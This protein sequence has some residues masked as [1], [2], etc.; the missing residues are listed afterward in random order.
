[1]TTTKTNLGNT[2]ER[3]KQL[4][5]EPVGTI[6][7]TN[8][9]DAIENVAILYSGV[10]GVPLFTA[11]VVEF[12]DTI[13]SGSFVR[14][15]TPTIVDPTL[16]GDITIDGNTAIDGDITIDG[17]V[18]I[19]GDIDITAEAIVQEAVTA[20][21]MYQMANN[22]DDAVFMNMRSTSTHAD[23]T[24]PLLI[25]A[26][27]AQNPLPTLTTTAKIDLQ[28]G[29]HLSSSTNPGVRI[30]NFASPSDRRFAI[31]VNSS[32]ELTFT[33]DTA[34]VTTA[35]VTP[36]TGRWNLLKGANVS[37]GMTID[38]NIGITAEVIT[39][40]AFTASGMYQ[41][42]NDADGAIFMSM[43]SHATDTAFTFP[44]LIQALDAA[45][46]P[47]TLTTTAKIDLQGG[48]RLS[49]STNPGVMMQNFA[50]PSD[51]HC[52]M[53]VNSSGELMFTDDI[54]GF[55]TAKVS[56]VTGVWNFM[57]GAKV[58]TAINNG[59]TV[60]DGTTTGIL[61]PSSSFGHSLAFGTTSAHPIAIFVANSVAAVI[62]SG[63]VVGAATG[64]EKGDGTINVAGDIYKNNTAYTNPDYV[65]EH[66]YSGKIEQFKDREGASDY[67]GLM[68]LDGLS[69]Y[70]KEHHRLPRMSDEP[71]GMFKRGDI[72]LEK[73][74]E[75]TIYILQ[76]HEQI[77]DLR[78]RL[79]R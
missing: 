38:G 43:R 50:A 49:S 45:N 68:P 69:S 20:S 10:N 19:D 56:P 67:A 23:T 30:Q 61:F 64:S 73:I 7:A 18:T 42:V 44:L 22:A 13:G 5:F 15:D 37:E 55:T 59:L 21:V 78:S 72:A 77:N 63:I 29:V 74:E 40:E 57:K 32:G 9:Q 11:G 1:M 14:A 39:Q 71:A 33:D 28:G 52:A 41:M 46:A 65:F 8:V 34:A 31:T 6:E 26:R 36:A 3:A 66:F 62:G 25:Q 16:S 2:R 58:D 70:V 79:K 51:Q 4:R 76:L 48:V 47:P 17:G 12:V 60:T 27:D 24:F 75:L 54:A 53:V 35:K